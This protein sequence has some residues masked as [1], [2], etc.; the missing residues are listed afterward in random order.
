MKHL[1]KAQP[2]N[3]SKLDK[4]A[5]YENSLLQIKKKEKLL[6]IGIYALIIIITIAVML[7]VF[8]VLLK[9]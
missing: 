7:I 4:K 1:Q 5:P 6:S 2:L 9:I 8:N 3:A